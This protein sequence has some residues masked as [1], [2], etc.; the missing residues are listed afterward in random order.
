MILSGNKIKEE[1]KKGRITIEPFDENMLNPNSYNYELGDYLKVYD[2][3]ILDSKKHNETKN[4]V[5][6]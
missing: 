3:D 6:M 4:V 1:V 5:L 2:K